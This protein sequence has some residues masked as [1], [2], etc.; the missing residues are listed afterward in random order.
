MLKETGIPE[1]NKA[2]V[3][4]HELNED[5]TTRV[6]AEA[7]DKVIRD[8]LSALAYA[9]NKGR[10]EGKEEGKAEERA[11]II[12]KMRKSGMTDEQIQKIMNL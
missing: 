6:M 7:R 12:N 1:I 5:E 2:I 3:I 4:L 11:E 8:E 10:A 9:K